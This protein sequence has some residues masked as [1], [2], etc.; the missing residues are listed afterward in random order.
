MLQDMD[1]FVNDTYIDALLD[2]VLVTCCDVWED[3]ASFFPDCSLRMIYDFVQAQ[4]ETV[5]Y[6]NLSLLITSSN[7][8]SDCSEAWNDD[9]NSFML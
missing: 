1:E 8:V 9:W 3:P 6:N 2:L 4:N 7:D 5:I